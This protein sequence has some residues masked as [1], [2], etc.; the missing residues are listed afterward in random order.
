MGGSVARRGR[1]VLRGSDEEAVASGEYRANQGCSRPLQIVT[2]I[3]DEFDAVAEWIVDVS[4]A[5]VFEFDILFDGYVGCTE[6]R[7]ECVISLHTKCE[8]GLTSGAEIDFN[9]E[10]N[11]DVSGG[12]PSA[13]SET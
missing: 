8:V 10:M 2:S 5:N 7:D 9:A 4:T 11:G 1:W 3:G 6:L 13:S 12:K